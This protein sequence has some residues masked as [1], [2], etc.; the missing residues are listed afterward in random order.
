MADKNPPSAY[1]PHKQIYK[2]ASRKRS[3]CKLGDTNENEDMADKWP[4]K[5]AILK[6]YPVLWHKK[7]KKPLLSDES[8]YRHIQIARIG[9]TGDDPKVSFAT[10]WQRN[11]INR[12]KKIALVTLM[13]QIGLPSCKDDE[14][15]QCV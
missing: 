8:S 7:P 10:E 4:M 9:R 2:Q 14:I 15:F 1:N 13:T 5:S 12:L 3:I 11:Y 6:S